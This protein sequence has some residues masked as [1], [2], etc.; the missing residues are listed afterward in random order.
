[1]PPFLAELKRR[2]VIRIAIFYGAGAWLILQVADVLTGI[3]REH[4]VDRGAAAVQSSRKLDMA[5]IALLVLAIALLA[6]DDLSGVPG[7]RAEPAQ[8]PEAP[9]VAGPRALS[10]AV[11]PFVNV[12][13]KMQDFRVAGRTSS[14][15]FK[16]Q[17]QDLRAIGERLGVANILEGGVRKQGDKVRVTAQL[18][19]ASSGYHLWSDTYDRRLDDVF[20]IQDDI[21][22]EVVKALRQTLLAA[23]EAIISQ[24]AK[25]DV[26]AYNHYLRGQFHVRLR[27]RSGLERALEEFQQAILV[28]PDYAPPHAGIAMVYALLDNYSYRSLGETGELAH[29]A[30]ERAL[31]RAVEINPNNA[32]AHLWLSSTLFPDFEAARALHGQRT[33]LARPSTPS[34]RPRESASRGEHSGVTDIA[35]AGRQLLHGLTEK[36]LNASYMPLAEG[37]LAQL[38]GREGAL[39]AGLDEAMRQGFRSPPA[40]LAWM[41]PLEHGSERLPRMTRAMEEVLA[42]ERRRYD[43]AK[44]GG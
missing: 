10:I 36:G 37:L 30:L 11:L 12:L 16:G 32:F 23:D 34:T 7:R 14:F 15:A 27:T 22:T 5:T 1:M 2:N 43:A 18:I 38:E 41:L 40:Y 26:E 25:G 24:T 6:W 44:A 9:A 21:A 29:A 42:E 31:E 28:D 35:A 13:A 17:Q 33:S 20:A 19:D 8:A 4:E 3:K 39:E